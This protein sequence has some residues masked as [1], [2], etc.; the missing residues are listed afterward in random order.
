[1]NMKERILAETNKLFFAYG[2]RS[3]TMDDIAKNLSISKKSIYQYFEDKDEIVM[4]LMQQMVEKNHCE[5]KF[6][7][8][9]PDPI[10]GLIHAAHLIQQRLSE[11]NPCFM[12]DL[13]KY[14]PKAWDLHHEYMN[15]HI[16]NELTDTIQRG[17]ASGVFRSDIQP[18]IIAKMRLEQVPVGFDTHIFPVDQFD[19]KEVQRQFADHFIRGMLSE[20]GLEIYTQF[21]QKNE[22][23]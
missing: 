2:I 21:S 19:L 20:K 5:V 6:F 15:K 4:T 9:C 13:R 18:K 14:Y 17:I 12:L 8:N 11:I 3:V 16:Y 23:I 7:F 10:Q 22:V 1:M